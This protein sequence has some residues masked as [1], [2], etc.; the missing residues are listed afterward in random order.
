[1]KQAVKVLIF[2][3]SI[4]IPELNTKRSPMSHKYEQQEAKGKSPTDTG[5][6]GTFSSL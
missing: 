4:E 1:M 3:M 2:T 5:G 6:V